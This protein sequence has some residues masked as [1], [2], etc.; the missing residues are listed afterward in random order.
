MRDTDGSDSVSIV[1]DILRSCLWSAG[2]RHTSARLSGHAKAYLMLDR[3]IVSWPKWWVM[4][5]VSEMKQEG[6]SRLLRT[7]S[8]LYAFT[9]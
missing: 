2:L 1:R 9:S 6:L 5:V 7:V 3:C 4:E 8:T